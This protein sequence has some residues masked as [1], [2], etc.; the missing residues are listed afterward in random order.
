MNRTVRRWRAAPLLIL[1]FLAGCD[2]ERTEL[3][4]ATSPA[5]SAASDG[6]APLHSAGRD[7][8]P[9]RFIV[10]FKD[11]VMQASAVAEQMVSTYG[12]KLHFSYEN[13]IKGF[14]ASLSDEAVEALR[15]NRAVAYIAQDGIVR[16]TQTQQPNA[17]W[18]LDRIDQRDLPL[19]TRYNYTPNGSGVRV[20]VLDTGIRTAHNEFGG[21]AS[22]GFDAIGDGQNGQDCQGHGTHVAG[23]VAGA[24]YGVAKGARVISVRVLNCEGSGTWAGVIAGVDWVSANR[25]RPAV[26]NMSLGGGV[27]QPL[28]DAVTA[29][30]NRGVTYV[31]AAGNE[32]TDACSKSPASTPAAITVGS[33]TEHDSQSNFSNWGSCV[34]V[35]A[36]GSDI[37]SAWHTSNTATNTIGGTSMAA[38]H[39]AGIA[40]LYLQNN[41][42]AAPSAVAQAIVS[43]ASAA[44]L[45]DLGPDSPNLLAFSGLTVEPPLPRITLDPTSL[46]FTFLRAVQGQQLREVVPADSGAIPQF[47]SSHE[48]GVKMAAAN[49]ATGLSIATTSTSASAIVGLTNSGIAPLEWA[50]T[51]NRN[52]LSASPDEG[53]LSPTYT[54]RIDASV[55]SAALAVGTHTGRLTLSDQAAGIAPKDVPVSVRVIQATQ[56]DLGTSRANQSGVSGSERYYVVEVPSGLTSLVIRITGGTGDADMHVRYGAPPTTSVYDCRPFSSGNEET[57][58]TQFPAAGT[59]YVMLHAFSGYSGV[60]ISATAGGPPAAPA[61]LAGTAVSA[62]Q[63]NLT[64]QDNSSNETG[65]TLQRSTRNA[66]GT[67]T[68]W[69]GVG[70]P[71]AN[72]TSFS[73][74]GLVGNTTYRYRI[75]SCNQAGCSGWANSA[76]VTTPGSSGP[77]AVPTSLAAVAVSESQINLTW[78]DNSNNE[79]SFTLQRKIRNAD[80]TWT[81]WVN[82][83]TPAAN[84]TSYSHTGLTPNT[85]YQ[86]RIR[87]CNADGCSSWSALSNIVTTP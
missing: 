79:T 34:D 47:E 87:A 37:T 19:D 6:V 62:S 14:A 18:G 32:S 71:A 29:S 54:A 83:A 26:A 78:A 53:Y 76:N 81:T 41:V 38:P 22:V 57:C 82:A 10:V 45:S 24:T 50:A 9:G 43:S 21:R 2:K 33:T 74:T 4:T 67:W 51:S 13:S 36:P 44:R 28:N 55:N 20:Y 73:N 72:A 3:P 75:R 65:F 15:R 52:W 58:T 56:L 60:T 12:G 42:N 49:L 68:A 63:I 86:Y 70:S 11:E 25:V 40:A 46:A 27:H 69:A 30:I 80:G 39:V 77:P 31:L 85:T 59:Y 61:N 84:T 16:I 48:G 5:F 35:Y 64:W 7:A 17:T 23:T 8:I 1:G 66:D